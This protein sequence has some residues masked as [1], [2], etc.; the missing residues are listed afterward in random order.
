G[1]NQAV[2][3]AL[4]IFREKCPELQY[5]HLTGIK[6]HDEVVAAYQKMGMKAAV[7]PFL[8]E[9]EYA[10]GAA[11]ASISRS[12]ASSLAEIAAF[13][14]PSLLV[15]YPHAADDHQYYNGLLFQEAGAAQMA[16]QGGLNPEK[17]VRLTLPLLL[18]E[19]VRNTMMGN[20]RKLGVKEAAQK[21]AARI[22]E[23]IGQ[24]E[25]VKK[26]GMEDEEGWLK[27]AME[28]GDLPSWKK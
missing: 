15:P 23:E 6:Q 28:N 1:I 22:L 16:A 2:I 4:P 21:I 11:T 14:L 8:T 7:R 19:Q 18:D 9:M 26:S 25:R 5:I 20:L 12:G 3:D 27:T 10:L 13:E 24:G 17:L